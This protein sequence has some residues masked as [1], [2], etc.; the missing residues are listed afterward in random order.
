MMADEPS[1][2]FQI[3][4]LHRKVTDHTEWF[5]PCKKV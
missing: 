5:K 1:T 2:E 3:K 4:V